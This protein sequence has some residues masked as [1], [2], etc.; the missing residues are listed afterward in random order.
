M[1]TITVYPDPE[2]KILKKAVSEWTGLPM[3][4]IIAGNG[5]IEI[6]YLLMKH[7][8]PR[9]A[10]IPAPTFNEYE[11]SVQIAG[12]NVKDLLLSEEKEFVLE[13]EPILEN[14]HNSDVIF[15]CNPNNPTGTLTPRETIVEI[16][17][18]AY[19]A[20]KVV[21]VDEAFIDFVKER[22]DYSVADLVTK[23][24]N[25]FV[26]YSLTKF[27]AI[28]GLRLGL[29]FGNPEIISKLNEIRDPWNVNCFAQLAGIHS[30]GDKQY[31]NKTVN[32]ISEQK[33]YLY[34]RLKS[35]KGLKP[36]Y[37]SANYIFINTEKTG[38]TSA[39]ITE[40]LGREGV[41]VR[42]CSSYKNLRPVFI[43]TAVKKHDDNN[44]LLDTLIRL[45]GKQV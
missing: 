41:L 1:D 30:I 6:I 21:V 33:D 20:G 3:N 7:H 13:I 16:V 14:W 11:I 22:Q 38:F 10:L 37:P 43:R 17:K 45:G 9:E 12:G 15:I 39:E 31:I 5:A 19:K 42:D 34:R 32:Y 25:L 26:L 40:S 18:Q 35:I 27:F 24:P 29:G 28:P 44:R 4:T 8:N 36:F 23:F 2:A